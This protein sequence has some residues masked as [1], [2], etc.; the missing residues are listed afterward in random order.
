VEGK[1][2][3]IKSEHEFKLNVPLKY[4]HQGEDHEARLIILKAPTNKIRGQRAKLKQAFM[5]AISEAESK[6]AETASNDS[7]DDTI[8]EDDAIADYILM[9]LYSSKSIKITT[10]IEEFKDL[11]VNGGVAMIENTTKMTT[12]LFENMDADDCDRMMGEYMAN[13]I[14]ASFLNKIHQK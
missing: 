14:L 8:I 7:Q 11:I 13:F 4:Q 9:M 5:Q 10:I 6:T 1:K 12:P 2:L 3:E